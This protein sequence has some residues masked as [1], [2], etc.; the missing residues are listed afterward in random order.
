LD[1][2]VR[3]KSKPQVLMDDIV[4]RILEGEF[5]ATGA[6]PKEQDLQEQYG[7]ARGTVRTAVHGLADR[8][9]VRVKHG[10]GGAEIVDPRDWDLFDAEIV[11]ALAETPAG[12]E[13]LEEGLECRLL[14]EPEA[15]ALAAGRA[16]DD[17]LDALAAAV[18]RLEAAAGKGAKGAAATERRRAAERDFHRGLLEAAHN[19][20]LL[21]ALEPLGLVT[22]DLAAGRVAPART[23]EQH[24]RILDALRAHDAQAAREAVRARL[25]ALAPALARRRRRPA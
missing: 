10:V 16:G 18:E 19:R 13:A 23:L 22:D 9:V 14:L 24:R 1:D 25:E 20:F 11:A 17:D 12:R 2:L 6:I 4:G 15:A 5:A 3:M 21:Q 8:R 7:V